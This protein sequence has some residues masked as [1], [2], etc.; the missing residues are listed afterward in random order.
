MGT[1]EL[2]DT[3]NSVELYIGSEENQPGTTTDCAEF[4]S[5]RNYNNPLLKFYKTNQLKVGL[6]I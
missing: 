6:L 5:K 2:Y 3:D 1:F 4:L